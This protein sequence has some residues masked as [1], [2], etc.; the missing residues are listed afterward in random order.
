MR[1]KFLTTCVLL[2]LLPAQAQRISTEQKTINVGQVLYKTPVSADFKLKPQNTP[3][4]RSKDKLRLHDG[5]IPRNRRNG[6]GIHHH[7]RL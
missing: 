1:N 7:R 3:N 2:A 4:P 6:K 5:V